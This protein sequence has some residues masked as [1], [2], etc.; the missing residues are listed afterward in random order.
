LAGDPYAPV[1]QAFQ[2]LFGDAIKRQS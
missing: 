1:Y 2:G